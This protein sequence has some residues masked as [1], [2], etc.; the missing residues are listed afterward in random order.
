MLMLRNSTIVIFLIVI[1]VH[2]YVLQ[3]AHIRHRRSFVDNGCFG[4]HD[5]AK[6]RYMESLCEDC[7]MMYRVPDIYINCTRTVDTT[8]STSIAPARSESISSLF[9]SFRYSNKRRNPLNLDCV[10]ASETKNPRET[11]EKDLRAI[12]LLKHIKC[13]LN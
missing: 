12:V 3:T 7:Y 5:R 11:S 1:A 2:A 13:S 9:R 8:I 10:R 6:F 4:K